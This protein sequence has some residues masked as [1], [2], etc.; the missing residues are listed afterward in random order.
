MELAS[1]SIDSKQLSNPRL[2]LIRY[3]H[4]SGLLN[5]GNDDVSRR[6]FQEKLTKEVCKVNSSFEEQRLE[7]LASLADLRQTLESERPCPENSREKFWQK[8]NQSL[9]EVLEGLTRLRQFA[10]HNCMAIVKLQ[11]KFE[12]RWKKTMGEMKHEG[13]CEPPRSLA[14]EFNFFDGADF[15][16][17]YVLVSGL[18]EL[19]QLQPTQQELPIACHF[20]SSLEATDR[21]IA[22]T[23][24]LSTWPMPAEVPEIGDAA[25]PSSATAWSVRSCSPF[26]GESQAEAGLAVQFNCG[27][28][29]CETC[30]FLGTHTPQ[31]HAASAEECV[32]CKSGGESL[33]IEVAS[34]VDSKGIRRF[35]GIVLQFLHNAC[36]TQDL[37]THGQVHNGAL[38]T[39]KTD[40]VMKDGALRNDILLG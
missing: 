4:L 31:R 21:C 8:V 7:L 28:S 15:A 9:L 27:H 12:R 40:F 24:V 20:R 38:P 25:I 2:W 5:E 32:F 37:Q 10:V 26:R 33:A 23:S 35:R 29:L 3:R 30:Y 11:R 1:S 6:K 22:C 18:L 34:D 16:E 13:L 36:S 39:T 17:L 14:H 19:R